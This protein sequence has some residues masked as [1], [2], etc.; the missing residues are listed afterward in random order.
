MAEFQ[1]KMTTFQTKV[2]Q[3]F[4]KISQISSKNKSNVKRK[5]S[6]MPDILNR[7]GRK[8]GFW[9]TVCDGWEIAGVST[10]SLVVK[11]AFSPICI[12]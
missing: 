3:I 6:Q 4:S 7:K 8:I 5:I 11:G 2:S 9:P 1:A 12:V 10:A